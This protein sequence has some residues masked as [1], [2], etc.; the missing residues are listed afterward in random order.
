M[1]RLGLESS[2]SSTH[3]YSRVRSSLLIV[4]GM[5]SLQPTR[6]LVLLQERMRGVRNTIWMHDKVLNTNYFHDFCPKIIFVICFSCAQRFFQFSFARA[7]VYWAEKKRAL[8]TSRGEGKREVFPLAYFTVV[9]SGRCSAT[10]CTRFGRSGWP[11]ATETFGCRHFHT[12]ANN[13]TAEQHQCGASYVRRPE[14]G[15]GLGH[16]RSR[17]EA[18]TP[19]VGRIMMV[20]S[21]SLARAAATTPPAMEM[22]A[23]ENMFGSNTGGDP[24]DFFGAIRDLVQQSL[25]PDELEKYSSLGRVEFPA[26]SNVSTNSGRS[27][28][29]GRVMAELRREND[30]LVERV[31]VLEQALQKAEGRGA[32]VGSDQRCCILCLLASRVFSGAW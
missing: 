21:Q 8:P 5:V 2:I 13:S 12:T 23:S 7:P 15:Y 14:I 20:E 11:I 1:F 9:S 29:D 27:S 18:L 25:R 22:P 28:Q 17:C 24:L 3:V 30:R 32:R 26:A 19:V 6:R 31:H 4:P 16:N 10:L